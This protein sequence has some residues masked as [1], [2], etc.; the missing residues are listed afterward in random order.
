MYQKNERVGKVTH[1]SCY[2]Q[3]NS[4]LNVAKIGDLLGE[5]FPDLNKEKKNW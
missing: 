1:S 4:E 5:K 3:N 2:W